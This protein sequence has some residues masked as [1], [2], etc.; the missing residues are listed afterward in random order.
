MDIFLMWTFIYDYMQ[1]T[2]AGIF[3]SYEYYICLQCH[4]HMNSTS[5]VTLMIL[6]YELKK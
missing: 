2:L 6:D 3:M 4:Y 1:Y 5:H